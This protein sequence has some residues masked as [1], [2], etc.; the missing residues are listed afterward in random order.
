[1]TPTDPQPELPD[2]PTLPQR[3]AA[4]LA[5]AQRPMVIP[6]SVDA[7][8]LLAARRALD[9]GRRRR[10]VLRWVTAGTAAAAAAVVLVALRLNVP[11]PSGGAGRGTAAQ[12]AISDDLTAPRTGTILD[13]FRLARA[14]RDRQP[15]TRAWDA[16]GDG[17]VDT[18]DVEAL[19][20]VAVRLGPPGGVPR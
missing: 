19:A 15:V 3:L 2:V 1:M 14:L 13:A 12:V 7:S 11:G 8:I 20:Q 18:Q 9:G 16:N 4:D 5:A 17:K 10:I 6:A